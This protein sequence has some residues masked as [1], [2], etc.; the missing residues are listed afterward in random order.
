MPP[1]R[2]PPRRLSH[3]RLSLGRRPWVGAEAE[4]EED[5]PQQME[6]QLRETEDP[7]TPMEEEQGAAVREHL[8]AV[9]RGLEGANRQLEADGGT[10]SRHKFLSLAE[11]IKNLPASS[12]QLQGQAE[13]LKSLG[14]GRRGPGKRGPTPAPSLGG[15]AELR[16][17]RQ[18]RVRDPASAP[19]VASRP[20]PPGLHCSEENQH[21]KELLRTLRARLGLEQ[22][23]RGALEEQLGLVLKENEELERQ[24]GAARGYRAA[25]AAELEASVA[26]IA[27]GAAAGAPLRGR[28]AGARLP[29]CPFQ[30]A[31]P[32]PAGRDAPDG[33]RVPAEPPAAQ[34]QRR[35]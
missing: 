24:L 4:A 31:R 10:A 17:L 14:R 23:R 12:Q 15:G 18:H 13:E 26:E 32:E 11:M 27:A 9:A 21:L 8:V 7:A 22:Q 34:Q 16:E 35:C 25:R 19:K 33:A 2:P 20:G 28:N 5:S 29:V 30:R 1:L 6:E 3:W